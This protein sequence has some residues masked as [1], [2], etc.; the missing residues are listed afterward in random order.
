[1]LLHSAC[2]L[3]SPS[4]SAAVRLLIACVAFLQARVRASAEVSELRTAL[5]AAS[6]DKAT[7]S[8]QLAVLKT[9]LCFALQVRAA[10]ASCCKEQLAAH[11]ATH[12]VRTVPGT[13]SYVS[14]SECRPCMSSAVL[15]GE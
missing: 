5:E 10:A 13:V 7:L 11:S 4:T 9:Q 12:L 2:C 1:M 6:K 14:C 15:P 3:Q 8:E